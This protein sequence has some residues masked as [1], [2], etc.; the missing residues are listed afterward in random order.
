MSREI[1]LETVQQLV[2]GLHPA[3][4]LEILPPEHYARE[5]LPGALNLPLNGLDAAAERV[6]PSQDTP[7]VTYCSG[8]TCANSHIAAR[9]LSELGYRDVRVFTGG[10]SAWRDAGFVFEHGAG[11]PVMRSA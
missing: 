3:L 6:I 10:K 2:A 5:H 7:V 11:E 1:S 8:P 4:V 9:R